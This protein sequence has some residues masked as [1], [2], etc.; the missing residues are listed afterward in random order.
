[1]SD[2]FRQLTGR[3]EEGRFRFGYAYNP[4]VGLVMV[5]GE[6]GSDTYLSESTLDG[7]NV[8]S[9]T[10]AEFGE[11][12]YENCLVSVNETTL[13]SLGGN[14]LNDKDR[15]IAIHTIGNSG[16]EVGAARTT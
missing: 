10:V 13:L 2:A 8:D 12:L 14:S 9:S 7:V 15:T 3:I 6:G 5:G 11:E 1:M 4:Q 16:W